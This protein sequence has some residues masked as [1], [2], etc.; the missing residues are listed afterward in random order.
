METKKRKSFLSKK[1]WGEL[2]GRLV[3]ALA[4][5][6]FSVVLI[7]WDTGVI[8][9]P[10]LVRRPRRESPTTEENPNRTDEAVVFDYAAYAGDILASLFDFSQVEGGAELVSAATFDQKGMSIVKTPLEPGNHN[11]AHGFLISE[12]EGAKQIRLALGLR[13]IPGNQEYDLT[14]YRDQEGDPVFKKKEDGSYYRLLLSD[15]SFQ[16]TDF[17]P[18]RDGR[19]ILLP[20]PA[21]YGVGEPERKLIYE[22]G[23]FGYTGTYQNGRRTQTF[24]VPPQY[25]TA[26]AYSEGFAVMADAEGKVTIRNEKGEVV[27]SHLS[28]I[29]PDKTGEE[30]L[31]FS[32]FE[33][34]LLRVVFASYDEQGVLKESREGII[35]RY[36][37]EFSLPEGF[38][39]VSYHQGVFSVTD[40]KRFGYFTALGAWLSDPIYADASPF[41][42]GLATVTNKDGKM[43]VVDLTGKEVIP[44]SFDQISHFSEGHAVMYSKTAGWYLISKVN[45][46]FPPAGSTVPEPSSSYYTKITITRGPQNT[47]DHEDDIILEL[48]PILST[49]SYTTRPENTSPKK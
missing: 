22:N 36:G 13:E 17:D 32:Y 41:F 34:G 46:I 38:R 47:F 29:L 11:T 20:M 48:E 43:G 12:K 2:T 45:G 6:A 39:A 10:F 7:L 25:P 3:I 9:L 35:D 4:V 18:V 24:T 31:G 21:S 33:N 15:L 14:G 8:D 23:L 49:S 44:C 1:Q 28:L 5:V 19:G 27:F 16:P 40:G 37:Q 26:F 30:A 42:E